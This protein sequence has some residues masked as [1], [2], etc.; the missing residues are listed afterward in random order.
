VLHALLTAGGS[1]QIQAAQA[2]RWKIENW[3]FAKLL[4]NFLQAATRGFHTEAL[5][6]ARL[7]WRIASPNC[8]SSAAAEKTRSVAHP[9]KRPKFCD[10]GSAM[11]QFEHPVS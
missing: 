3:S 7:P 5:K 9:G 4:L 1:L 2:K 6:R 8:N 11:R 10:R